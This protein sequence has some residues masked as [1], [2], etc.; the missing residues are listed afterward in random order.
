M[1]D[2][3]AQPPKKTTALSHTELT[4]RDGGVGTRQHNFNWL[5]SETQFAPSL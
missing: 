1:V 4:K 3:N 5:Q 2:T